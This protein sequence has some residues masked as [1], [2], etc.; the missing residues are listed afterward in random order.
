[1]TTSISLRDV[2]RTF[3]ATRALADIDL[4]LKPGV[5][6]LLGPNGVGKG[7]TITG[8]LPA[9]ERTDAAGLRPASL[10]LN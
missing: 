6:G 9:S 5:T 8:R 7:T 3:G 1:M 2:G 10:G 4:D